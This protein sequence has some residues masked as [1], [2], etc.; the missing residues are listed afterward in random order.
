MR[1]DAEIIFSHWK[2]HSQD[3]CGK[4]RFTKLVSKDLLDALMSTFKERGID[5][6]IALSFER[7]AVEFL[8]TED[9]LRGGKNKR[10]GRDYKDWTKNVKDSYKSAVGDYYMDSIVGSEIKPDLSSRLLSENKMVHKWAK[11]RFGEASVDMINNIC[12]DGSS[13]N[14]QMQHEL[15]N[16]EWAMTGENIP[17]WAK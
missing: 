7:K 12:M 9:G 17:E 1:E 2:E 13:L 5:K 15:F 16:A 4:S 10:T 8:I 6:D 3:E 11:Y 14:L